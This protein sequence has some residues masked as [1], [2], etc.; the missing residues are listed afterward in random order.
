MSTAAVPNAATKAVT[1]TESAA[2]EIK[3]VMEEQGL[4]EGQMLRIGVAGGGCSGFQ[5]SLGFE[6]A[7]AADSTKDF[8]GDQH[9]VTVAVDKKSALYLDGTTVDFYSGVD[10]RGFTFDNPNAVKSCGCG[11]SF[12]A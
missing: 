10:R 7:D 5:Y 11:S 12:S 3:R 4:I 8:V 2:A 1:I 9:G 6:D